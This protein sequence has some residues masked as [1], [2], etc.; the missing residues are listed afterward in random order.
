MSGAHSNRL[1]HDELS[2]DPLRGFWCNGQVYQSTISLHP[3]ELLQYLLKHLVVQAYPRNDVCSSPSSWTHLPVVSVD[4]H[5]SHHTPT[6]VVRIRN[7]KGSRPPTPS[8][9]CK[10]V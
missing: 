2:S 7:R 9:H 8:C 4:R 6:W 1:V 10:P 3:S 5:T